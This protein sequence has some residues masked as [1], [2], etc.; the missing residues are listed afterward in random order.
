M[1]DLIVS[2]FYIYRENAM[3][4]F[5]WKGDVDRVTPGFI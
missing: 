4:K 3:E 2:D 1:S 5:E